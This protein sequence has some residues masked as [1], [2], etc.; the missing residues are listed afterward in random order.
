MKR[1]KFLNLCIV[2]L[3]ISGLILAGCSSDDE[4]GAGDGG[5]EMTAN[6]SGSGS[7]KSHS[8]SSNA[9]KTASS[10]GTSLFVQ[11]TNSDG[12]G[13]T[14][15]IMNYTGEDTYQFGPVTSNFNTASYTETNV[16]SPSN[17]QVWSASYDTSSSGSITISEETDSG[18]KGS[19]S[20]KG[21]NSN[22]DSIK[23]IS[24]G[25]FDLNFKSN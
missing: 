19:F 23:T 24:D 1:V 12:V 6:I 13:I 20:F 8:I 5:G 16:S 2:F 3:T 22:D 25:N 17:T 11:G 9:V 14:M 21:K 18:V 10:A 4:S 15:T 7:F